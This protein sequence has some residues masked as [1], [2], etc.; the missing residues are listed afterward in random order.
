MVGKQASGAVDSGHARRDRLV[1]R[2]GGSVA[3]MRSRCLELLFS[4][5][6]LSL[7]ALPMRHL[8][9]LLLLYS[10]MALLVDFPVA[11]EGGASAVVILGVHN[12][13]T[14]VIGATM[15]SQ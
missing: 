6:P 5:L 3:V 8:F 7:L 2:Q 4:V 9:L 11:I 12:A 13:S 14:P 10:A 1:Q 15:F